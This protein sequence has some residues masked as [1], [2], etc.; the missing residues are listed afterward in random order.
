M[1]VPLELAGLQF[2]ARRTVA[3]AIVR[4]LRGGQ[5][6]RQPDQKAS[7]GKAIRLSAPLSSFRRWE[8]LSGRM[9]SA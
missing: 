5:Q 8:L 1:L 4:R 9:R 3:P 6:E 2:F 7:A